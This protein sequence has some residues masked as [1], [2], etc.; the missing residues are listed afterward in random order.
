MLLYSSS[1][2]VR[3]ALLCFTLLLTGVCAFAQQN[4]PWI[5]FQDTATDFSGYKDLRG[6]VRIPPVYYNFSNADTFHNI[7]SVMDSNYVSYYLLKNGRRI[8][9]DSVYA[10][11]A[12]GD[13]E[14]EEKILFH[15]RKH[16]RVGFFDKNGQAAIP[17]LYNYASSFHNG[18][19]IACRNA[20]R[21]CYDRSGDTLHCEH[22]GWDGGELVLI[23]AT[24]EILADSLDHTTLWQLNWYD[25][26][27]ND[28]AIDTGIYVRIKGRNGNV[29]A[30]MDYRKEFERWFHQVFMPELYTGKQL[31]DICFR[32]IT[33]PSPQT[34]SW[35]QVAR[36]TFLQQFTQAYLRKK[37]RPDSIREITIISEE[38]NGFI[39]EHPIYSRFFTACHDAFREKY[40]AFS[41]L[42]TIYKKRAEPLPERRYGGLAPENDLSPFERAYE[43]DYQE[44]VSF[45]RTEEGYKLLGVSFN[46]MP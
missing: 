21:K 37:L 23:N 31:K 46:D 13:C 11:D 39:Y 25:M 43:Q 33:Y 44:S 36:D 41:V 26:H 16:D 32:E 40:P 28:P 24:H 30:F 27:V 14:C 5:R 35:V 8:G 19:A 1:M 3:I 4:E 17:A 12:L 10:M 9:Y 2:T 42:I 6:R 18:I 7:M 38:L 20:R 29:Y 22:L 34:E 15:D 45:I